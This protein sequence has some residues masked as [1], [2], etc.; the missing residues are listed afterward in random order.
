MQIKPRSGSDP[1][2]RNRPFLPFADSEAG[3]VRG[4]GPVRI[5]FRFASS[6]PEPGKSYPGLVSSVVGLP[7]SSLA[8]ALRRRVQ[9]LP[10]ARVRCRLFPWNFVMGAI[11]EIAIALQPHSCFK[12]QSTAA[13]AAEQQ[14]QQQN[15]S[16]LIPK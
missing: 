5:R 1:N 9:F 2:N 4:P 16:L 15:Q 3:L 6:E 8:R 7:H 10:L 13:A 11:L 12:L 14:Q